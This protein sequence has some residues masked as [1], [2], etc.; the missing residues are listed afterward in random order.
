MTVWALFRIANNYDQPE[1]DLQKLYKNKPTFEQLLGYFFPGTILSEI[2]EDFL[3][4]VVML[5]KGERVHLF[6]DEYR[7]EEVEVEA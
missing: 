4:S 5:L 7:I 6:G 3:I 2:Q 1:N